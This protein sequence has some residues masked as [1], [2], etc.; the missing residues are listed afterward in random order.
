[1]TTKELPPFFLFYPYENDNEDLFIK[2]ITDEF[3]NIKSKIHKLNEFPTTSTDC[4]KVYKSLKEFNIYP[5]LISYDKKVKADKDEIRKLKSNEKYVVMN[6]NYQLAS[7]PKNAIKTV[8]SKIKNGKINFNNFMSKFDEMNFTQYLNTYIFFS[9]VY[10]KINKIVVTSI[11]LRN[12]KIKYCSIVDSVSWDHLFPKLELIDFRDNVLEGKRINKTYHFDGKCKFLP[13]DNEV[14]QKDDDGKKKKNEKDEKE[15][16]EQ[17]IKET[18]EQKVEENEEQKVEENKEQKIEVNKEQKVEENKEQ[19][20]E[21]NKEQKIDDVI[22]K[23]MLLKEEII[24]EEANKTTKKYDF[25]TIRAIFSSGIMIDPNIHIA[26]RFIIS[27]FTNL[28]NNINKISVFYHKDS[29]FSILI[30]PKFVNNLQA[31]SRC[32]RNLIYHSSNKIYKTPNDIQ[33]I[34]HELFPN[35]FHSI[36][37][38]YNFVDFSCTVCSFVAKGIFAFE[39]C[40]LNYQH[41]KP[42]YRFDRS[43]TLLFQNNKIFIGNENLYIYPVDDKYLSMLHSNLNFI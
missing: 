32:S 11:D 2:E 8:K 39:D 15:N 10:T 26:S 40:M 38:S 42:F 12:N 16:K 17:K 37:Q 41:N 24:Q 29:L 9:F 34:Q 23:P 7:K 14:K 31:I 33:R 25:D 13:F 30:D 27:F 36:I 1:M 28:K 5:L 21:V 4:N 18:K 6:V 43:F 20:I 3:P 22:I 35:G 19:K